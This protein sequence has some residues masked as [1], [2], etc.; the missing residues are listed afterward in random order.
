VYPLYRHWDL[1]MAVWRDV[2]ASVIIG[3]YKQEPSV[4]AVPALGLEYGG[5][6]GRGC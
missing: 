2:A 5:V 4:P 1:S 6:A 3:S